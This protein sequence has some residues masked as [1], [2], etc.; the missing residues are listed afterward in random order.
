MPLT[1]SADPSASF[2][3][4]LTRNLTLPL[5]LG[6]VSAVAFLSLLAYLA[7]AITS[8]QRSDELLS[9]ASAVQKL[10][11]EMESGVARL[12]A[13]RGRTLPQAGRRCGRAA[14]PRWRPC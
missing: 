9:Q 14:C 12:P 13:Q 2:R 5:V 8:V 10:D 7:A 4:I 3:R 6:V 1:H 11:L